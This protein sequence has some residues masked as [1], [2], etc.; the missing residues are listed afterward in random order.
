[1]IISACM[2]CRNL[3]KVHPELKC[4]QRERT[5]IDNDTACHLI[6]VIKPNKVKK[7]EDLGKDFRMRSWCYYVSRQF[8]RVR[9]S[10]KISDNLDLEANFNDSFYTKRALE[11]EKCLRGCLGDS[12]R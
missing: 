11:L 6:T 8:D 9:K 10:P 5:G 12:V 3:C 4:I 2:A 7:S 1:M